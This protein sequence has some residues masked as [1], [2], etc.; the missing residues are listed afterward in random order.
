MISGWWFWIMSLKSLGLLTWFCL[1]IGYFWTTLLLDYSS[2]A[3][4]L[5]LNLNVVLSFILVIWCSTYI[6]LSTFTWLIEHE[7]LLLV[8]STLFAAAHRHEPILPIS[9]LIVIASNLQSA[10]LHTE[11]RYQSLKLVVIVVH[12]F[13]GNLLRKRF[14][15]VLGRLLKIFKQQNENLLFVSWNFD[16]VDQTW[17]LMEVTIQHRSLCFDS[18]F[19][20]ADV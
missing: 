9:S 10:K 8:E 12:E 11:L 5:I 13:V 2:S 20:V 19:V 16:Q 4:V 6:Y 18:E 3:I 1:L 17:N 7:L 15:N 14:S